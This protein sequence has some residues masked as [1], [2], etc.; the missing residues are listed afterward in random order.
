MVFEIMKIV[1]QHRGR[2]YHTFYSIFFVK[3]VIQENRLFFSSR[4]SGIIEKRS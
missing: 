1:L 2:K 4:T 3:I